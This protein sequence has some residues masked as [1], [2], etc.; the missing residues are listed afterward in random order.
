MTAA[1]QHAA[2]SR[3]THQMCVLCPALRGRAGMLKQLHPCVYTAVMFDLFLA[4]ICE[5]CVALK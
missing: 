1:A 5:I 3:T 4:P 2:F